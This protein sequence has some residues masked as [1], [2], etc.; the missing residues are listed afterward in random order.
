MEWICVS[1]EEEVKAKPTTAETQWLERERKRR[2]ERKNKKS[3]GL[4]KKGI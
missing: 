4:S 1:R 3:S 2:K